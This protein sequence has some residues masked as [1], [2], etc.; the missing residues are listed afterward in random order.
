MKN[1]KIYFYIYK[2]NVKIDIYFD[3]RYIFSVL[4]S[5]ELQIK[6]ELERQRETFRNQLF[7]PGSSNRVRRLDNTT[8]HEKV[9]EEKNVRTHLANYFAIDLAEHRNVSF[10]HTFPTYARR[11]WERTRRFILDVSSEVRTFVRDEDG[12]GEGGA[13]QSASQKNWD[14]RGGTATPRAAPSARRE[15]SRPVVRVPKEG[16]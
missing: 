8:L 7:L 9:K 14:T 3:M 11:W 1:Y 12:G 4:N 13:Q 2:I 15:G 16:G 10:R 5:C 6:N